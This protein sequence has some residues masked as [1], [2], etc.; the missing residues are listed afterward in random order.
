MYRISERGQRAGIEVLELAG[1]EANIRRSEHN[2]GMGSA[3]GISIQG[4]R[5]RIGVGSTVLEVRRWRCGVSFFSFLLFFF[6]SFPMSRSHGL[7]RFRYCWQMFWSGKRARFSFLVLVGKGRILAQRLFCLWQ[8]KLNF[9]GF[10][11]WKNAF[12]LSYHDFAFSLVRHISL[13]LTFDS[14][15]AQ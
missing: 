9:R 1:L 12:L 2:L 15:I 4:L 14:Y 5:H 8:V 7:Q 10:S 11:T 6:S 13:F 3:S